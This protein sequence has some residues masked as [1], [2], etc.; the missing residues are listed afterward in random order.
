MTAHLKEKTTMTQAEY[1]AM[2]RCAINTKHEYFSGEIFAM[3]G[4]KRN[5]VYINSNLIIALGGKLRES[6]S[7]CRPVANDM[8]VKIEAGYVYP[9]VVIL[10]GEGEFED[11]E[12]DT[13]TN[14]V[15][16]IEILSDS[17]AA[18]DRGE[19]FNYYQGIATLKEYILVSQ[20]R[21]RIEQYTRQEKKDTWEYRSLNDVNQNLTIKSTDCEV[22]LSEIYWGVEFA[23]DG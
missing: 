2:E 16:I 9:D 11:D 18:F 6:N 23:S 21:Y 7:P 8:R 15:V 19:K 20:D 14:P 3:V 12:F 17:T 1:L 4:G 5:H 13:L 10:C 22:S